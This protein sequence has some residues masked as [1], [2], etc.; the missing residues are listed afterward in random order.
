[1]KITE[2]RVY[3]VDLTLTGKAVK[4]PKK[5]LFIKLMT[6][7]GIAGYGETSEIPF[8]MASTVRMIEEVVSQLVVGTDPHDTEILHRKIYMRAYT[9]RPEKTLMSVLSVIDMACW[10]IVGKAA[11]QPVCNLLGGICRDTIRTYTYLYSNNRDKVRWQEDI[12]RYREMGFTALKFDPLPSN[13]GPVMLTSETLKNF[14]SVVSNTREA[15]GDQCDILVGSHGQ[16]STAEAVRIAGILEP[17]RPLWFEEPVG[18]ENPEDMA[19]VARASRVP[20]AAG[21]RLVGKHE[22]YRLIRLQ[23]VGIIQP[24]LGRVGGLLEAKK[25]AGMA[26]AAYIQMAPH[27]FAGPVLAAA[28]VQLDICSPNF[29]I[30]EGI[31][32]WGD[33]WDLILEEPFRWEKGY[34][35][36][37]MKPGLGVTLNEDVLEHYAEKAE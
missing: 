11:G 10:D 15:A 28:S 35:V 20:V 25:I 32:T 19:L 2:V 33:A 18:P 16:F 24:D 31:Y 29:L 14:E 27:V 22:F 8:E 26:E 36:P 7:E 12:A 5:L 21:E 6:D 23:G 4:G 34:L 1:M 37:S 3:P 17:Y 13:T 30:Q 9:G